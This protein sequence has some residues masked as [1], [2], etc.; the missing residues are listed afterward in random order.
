MG[1]GPVVA[2]G[3]GGAAGT[4]A[5]GMG[6]GATVGGGGR[7]GMGVAV[8]SAATSA[9]PSVEEWVWRWQ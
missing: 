1:N 2:V 3:C 7:V 4:I 8:G 9:L 6:V 5:V